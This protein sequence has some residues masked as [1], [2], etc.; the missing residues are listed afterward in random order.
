MNK[1]RFMTKMGY[2]LG[3]LHILWHFIHLNYTWWSSASQ[4][5][6]YSMW[7]FQMWKF[8][9]R[10]CPYK[11]F[12]ARRNLFSSFL[13]WITWNYNLHC[14]CNF[15]FISN[16][17]IRFQHTFQPNVDVFIFSRNFP[18]KKKSF[19]SALHLN[20]ECQKQGDRKAA[21]KQQVKTLKAKF[22]F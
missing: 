2:L 12:I 22:F 18:I 11:M 19:Q 5:P 6:T 15:L 16:V 17:R 14:E 10:K 20:V 9:M 7:K 13:T 8:P 4:L 21:T 1:I 3:I